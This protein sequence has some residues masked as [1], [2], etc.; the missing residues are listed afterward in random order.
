MKRS[1]SPLSII[2]LALVTSFLLVSHANAFHPTDPLMNDYYKVP[3]VLTDS[4]APST[5]IILDSSGSMRNLAYRTESFDPKKSYYGYFDS[6]AY[7]SFDTPNNYFEKCVGSPSSTCSYGNAPWSGNFLNWL[8]MRRVDVAKKVLTG[9]R[10]DTSDP[11]VLVLHP[12]MDR[13]LTRTYDDSSPVDDIN[14]LVR[15]T[16]SCATA[17]TTLASGDGTNQ[18]IAITRDSDGSTCFNNNIRV[19]IHPD[20]LINGSVEGVIQKNAENIRFGLT[21]FDTNDNDANED[22]PPNTLD[23]DFN[24]GEIIAP[25]GS[26]VNEVVDGINGTPAN[27][28]TP[29]AETLYTVAGNFMQQSAISLP[30]GP[31]YATDA[32][33]IGPAWDPFFFV[34]KDTLVHCSKPFVILITDGEP[35]MDENIAVPIRT[36]GDVV[37]GNPNPQSHF[38]TGISST[39]YADGTANNDYLENVAYWA[40]TTDLRA[41]LDD[42]DSDLTEDEDKQNL[43]L[44]TVFAFGSGNILRKAAINGSFI[45]KDGNGLPNS[46][47]AES[48]ASLKDKEWDF[49]GNGSP[50]N[51][52][53]ASDG[54]KLEEAL[55]AAMTDITGKLSSG[56]GSA[57]VSSSR[58]GEG[59]TIQAI[60]FPKY[61]DQEQL[62][63]IGDVNAMFV[64]AYGNLRE[65]TNQNSQLD[66]K[67][68]RVARMVSND[69]KAQVE[70][71]IDTDGNGLL[72]MDEDLDGDRGNAYHP[73][74]TADECDHNEDK[75]FDGHL[76]VA[77]DTNGN[78]RLD[79]ED[80]DHDCVLEF[81]EDL[82]GNG[83]F[84]PGE[85]IDGD[86]HFDNVDEDADGDCVMDTVNEDVDGDG[87]LDIF[88]DADG[89]GLL[90]TVEEDFDHDGLLGTV[91]EDVDGDGKLDIFEDLDGDGNLDV[92][93]DTNGNGVLDAGEDLDGDGNLDVNEDFDGDG[94]LG[95]TDED[96]D[97]DGYLDIF[98]DLDGD[99]FLDINEDHDGDGLLGTTAE[100]LNGDGNLD[101]IEDLDGDGKLDQGEDLNCNGVIDGE[102]IDG[103]CRLDLKDEDVDMDGHLDFEEDIDQDGICDVNE[104]PVDEIV[105]LLEMKFLWS[106][107]QH[108]ADMS[109]VDTDSRTIFTSFDSD[110][111]GM[112]E[113]G[114]VVMFN[115][116]GSNPITNISN[117][118]TYFNLPLRDPATASSPEKV[119]DFDNDNDTTEDPDDLVMLIDYI[120]GKDDLVFRSREITLNGM[121]YTWRLGDIINSSPM[122]VSRT[123]ENLDL[124][125]NDESYRLFKK[126]YIP[127]RQVVYTGSNDGML[128]AI[129]GGF[130]DAEINKVWRARNPN[131]NP[132]D[133][134]PT[135]DQEFSDSGP[136]LGAELW[137]Y[138]P[139][140]LLPH[141]QWLAR[142]NYSHVFFVDKPC[143]IADVKIFAPEPACSA[144][145]NDPACIH[146]EGWGTI[147]IGGMR[148]GG[149]PI[150]VDYDGDKVLES[151]GDD[152]TLS[153]AYF[154]IDITDPETDPVFL[155]EF[156]FDDFSFTTSNPTVIQMKNS[157]NLETGIDWYLTF[158]TGPTTL[159]GQ[160]D[161]QG[162]IYILKLNYNP[163]THPGGIGTWVT[164]VATPD[165]ANWYGELPE[166]K[167]F[168]SDIISA[169]FEIGFATGSFQ[170]DVIY[171]GSTSGG[172]EEID[173]NNNGVHDA[174]E[175]DFNSDGIFDTGWSGNLYRII[176]DDQTDTENW[177]FG[178]YSGGAPSIGTPFIQV[179]A[180]ITAAPNV[181]SDEDENIWVYAGTGRYLDELDDADQSIQYLIGAMEPSNA[182]NTWT[183]ESVS[184]SDLLD[185]THAKVYTGFTKTD[186]LVTGIP[187]ITNFQELEDSIGNDSSHYRGWKKE[188]LSGLTERVI[189]SPLIFGGGVFSLTFAP[190]REV[191]ASGGWSYLYALYYLTGTAY[192]SPIFGTDPGD[193]INEEEAVIPLL[194]IGA[195]KPGGISIFNAS[196]EGAAS[197]VNTQGNDGRIHQTEIATPFNTKNRKLFWKNE[198]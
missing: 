194:S 128:R 160:S 79:G 90:G 26:T 196:D 78:G 106:A 105:D 34:N 102:D 15:H 97:G 43:T 60:F 152:R 62:T 103:D 179:G 134:D 84:D 31:R 74:G 192:Y 89:D 66:Y 36:A 195:G 166:E 91:A 71:F 68:D 135:N 80:V 157:N 6:M 48:S 95:T 110:G 93:E 58:S 32:Y 86:G 51:Y 171:F 64:D 125:Y 29:L 197:G 180:P 27:S 101:I 188:L 82:N 18:S 25:V 144:D 12:N 118:Y 77:E 55:T 162:K 4:E 37:D 38:T 14:N 132:Y 158:G 147:L 138:I 189:N 130:Y 83:I 145:I 165:G 156:T 120:R 42:G 70:L 161:Q 30:N 190:D 129:N 67:D 10:V 141:L 41:D 47:A 96:L 88:E 153:S 112:A 24:G 21:I 116:S 107:G 72:E 19:K 44:Y 136:E 75:D 142:K 54:K 92:D 172:W 94:F 23:M 56:S 198:L 5:M 150:T 45:D 8:T 119:L 53:E 173:T 146:P 73:A 193:T 131:F 52:A 191:C 65:D 35:T 154:V 7:Y 123:M 63:W 104:S 137:A 170:D 183:G 155:G 22:D 85:D 98:E 28:W 151:N 149:G 175:D 33:N 16:T 127:R 49:D 117:I 159:K 164:S 39:W 59:A 3:T 169:D 187:G 148:F 57:A 139:Y 121:Q 181:S 114:D 185:V 143:R 76:D 174:G 81:T 20:D 177:L 126:K 186:A 69:G 100:D 124:L 163:V 140:N 2:S 9:G 50:D 109:D 87:V 108:L 176:L 184:M 122:P 178:T 46:D 168:V 11:T 115:T 113:P 133:A 111:D 167:S 13:N 40:H 61:P 99:G 182:P 17:F 1:H